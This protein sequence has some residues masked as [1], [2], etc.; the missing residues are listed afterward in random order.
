MALT[1][2]V[3]GPP[4]PNGF[5]TAPIQQVTSFTTNGYSNDVNGVIFPL[6]TGVPIQNQYTFRKIPAESNIQVV[7]DEVEA[8]VFP[9][10]TGVTV[11]PS[12][13]TCVCQPYQTGT[14]SSGFTLPLNTVNTVSQNPNSYIPNISEVI[15]YN[16]I[17]PTIL[18]DCERCLSISFFEFNGGDY[19]SAATSNTAT[20]TVQ[21]LDY[22][23]I[24]QT[25]VQTIA[26]G[27]TGIDIIGGNPTSLVQSVSFNVNPFSGYSGA[28]TPYICVGNSTVIGLP[29][30][31]DSVA[32][33]NSAN[34]YSLPGAD[35]AISGDANSGIPNLSIAA[36][37]FNCV[38]Q[39]TG[40]ISGN[41]WRQ[42]ITSSST[43]SGL[44]SLALI[45][46]RGSVNL[47]AADSASYIDGQHLL[48]MNYFVSGS[49]SEINANLQNLN[50]S[51]LA[52]MQVAQTDSSTSQ[53]PAYAW[54]YVTY[55]DEVGLQWNNQGSLVGDNGIINSYIATLQ[56]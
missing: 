20:V 24:Q 9:S 54:P 25:F 11:I 31:L 12:W 37:G 36:T 52:I 4:G 1:T 30:Y 39:W 8:S 14:S 53:N 2:I 10:G 21:C 46:C 32:N 44:S 34:W 27:T 50:P 41:E 18:L 51:E 22:R 33:V 13:A 17:F 49:D 55:G 26:S 15:T 48:V 6:Q 38:W 43:L 5:P 45:A 47:T 40:I 29:Y 56:S 7:D 3:Q 35:S 28:G 42:N 19:F 23:Q 16:G